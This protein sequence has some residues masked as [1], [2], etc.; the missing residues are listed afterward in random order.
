MIGLVVKARGGNAGELDVPP[1]FPEV[2]GKEPSRPGG[3]N[4]SALPPRAPQGTE[5]DTTGI[6]VRRD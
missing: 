4:A 2:H 6:K 1:E 5:E 3:V